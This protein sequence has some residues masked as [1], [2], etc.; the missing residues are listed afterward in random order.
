MGLR[1]GRNCDILFDIRYYSS[2]EATRLKA[3]EKVQLIIALGH[4]G[5]H[6]DKQIAAECPLVDVV[7]GGHDNTFLWNGPA[8]DLERPYGPYPLVITQPGTGKRVPVVQAYAFTKYLGVLRLQ[9]SADGQIVHFGGQPLLLDGSVPHDPHVMELLEMYRP[10][11]DVF[12]QTVI[13]ESRVFLNGTCKFGECNLGNL[14]ADSMVHAYVSR[15]RGNYW[16]DTAIALINSGGIRTSG[17]AGNLT[18][19]DLMMIMP[20]DEDVVSVAL[21]GHELLQVL[22]H[23]VHRYSYTIRRGE[24]L[25]MSGIRVVYN[26]TQPSGARVHRVHMLCT[27]CEV[28]HYVALDEFK[29]Y[30]VLVNMFMNMGGNGFN[31][32]TVSH[33]SYLFIYFYFD[34]IYNCIQPNL[35]DMEGEYTGWRALQVLSE[36]ISNREIVYTGLEGRI[37]FIGHLVDEA[38]LPTDGISGRSCAYKISQT[39][40]SPAGQLVVFTATIAWMVNR[41]VMYRR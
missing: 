12:H 19:A 30:K 16:T 31:I 25:Q 1:S 33:E 2:L 8:P 29:T 13:G 17:S 32:L 20:F 36:Y 6:M 41:C 39:L 14:M 34:L 24:F 27:E 37:Q 21:S 11:V 40:R 4:S 35:Q 10:A 22:E 23:A 38:T 7:I 18:A 15:Y 28:P 26:L 9:L 5:I 3:V